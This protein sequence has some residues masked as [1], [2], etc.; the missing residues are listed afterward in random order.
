MADGLSSARSG[1]VGERALDRLLGRLRASAGWRLSSEGANLALHPLEG[2]GGLACSRALFDR[3]ASDGLVERAG[4]GVRISDLGLAR[5]DRLRGGADGFRVQ[6]QLRGTRRFAEPGGAVLMAEVNLAESP[7]AWLRTRRGRDG[8]SLIDEAQFAAGER[9]RADHAFG[10]IV[11]GLAR[12]SWEG[13]ATGRIDG[14]RGAGRGGVADLSDQTVAARERVERALRAVGQELTPVLLAVCC[15][16]KGLE[17]VE[18][19]RGWP[20]RSAKIILSLALTR[21]ARHYGYAER[22]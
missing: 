2:G 8:R 3:A 11:P 16:L 20:A 14:G 17:Q 10:Q 7:L 4:A 19:E 12:P 5:L 22:A 1:D 6:H 13:I 18:K 15:E 9:L 21:L